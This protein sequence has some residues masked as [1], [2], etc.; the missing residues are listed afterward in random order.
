MH[1]ARR[2]WSRFETLHAVAYFG[3][4]TNDAGR[5]AGMNGFWMSYF[6]FRAAPMGAVGAPVVEATFFNFAPAFVA[7]WVPDVWVHATPAALVPARAEAAAQTL[8][9]VVPAIADVGEEV[10]DA[11]RRATERVTGAGRPLFAANR[12]LSLPEDPVAALWQLCTTLREHRGDGHV[13]ALTVAGLDGIDA[14]VLIALERGSDPEDLQ[15]TR[16]WNGDD[17]ADALDRCRARGLV[18]G[19]GDLTAAGRALR[20][21]VEATTDRLAEDVW[22]DATADVDRIIAILNPAA[23]AVSRSGMIRYPNPI[24]LPALA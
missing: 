19:A 6:G 20:V 4:E 21:D 1:V 23:E 7:R 18:D 17:W 11:L 8:A 24:G 13:A 2:L 9:R 12:A 14:H 22:K 5:A 3:D 15:V 16:G 10:N